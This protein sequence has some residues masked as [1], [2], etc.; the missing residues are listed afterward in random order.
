LEVV[1]IAFNAMLVMAAFSVRCKV[2]GGTVPT[3]DG[4]I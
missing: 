4:R 3:S 2:C 1:V